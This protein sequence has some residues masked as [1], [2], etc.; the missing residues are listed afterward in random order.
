MVLLAGIQ[1]QHILPQDGTAVKEVGQRDVD[2]FSCLDS[3]GA[4]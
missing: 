3:K 4:K 1:A 2:R